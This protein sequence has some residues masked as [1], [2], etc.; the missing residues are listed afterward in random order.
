MHRLEKHLTHA[1]L[2]EMVD[3]GVRQIARYES[4]ETEP[5]G[6]IV[7][8]IAQVF[9]VSTDYLL[10]RTDDPMPYVRSM[11]DLTDDERYIIVSLRKRQKLD[12]IKAIVESA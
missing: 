4:G 7:A 1:D 12:A 9:N 5:N 3:I 2:A 6:E 8:R 11:D 10:G